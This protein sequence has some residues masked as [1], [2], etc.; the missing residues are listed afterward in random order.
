[1]GL[2]SPVVAELSDEQP[3]KTAVRTGRIQVRQRSKL[4]TVKVKGLDIATVRRL[5]KLEDRA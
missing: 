3:Y 2:A 4:K 5:L 1:M